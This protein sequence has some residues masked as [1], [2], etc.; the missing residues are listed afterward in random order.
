M[1]VMGFDDAVMK[2]VAVLQC[3]ACLIIALENR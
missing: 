2:H 3:Y 1:V